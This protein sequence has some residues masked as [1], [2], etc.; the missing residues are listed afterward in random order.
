MKYVWIIIVMLILLAGAFWAGT[1][2]DPPVLLGGGSYVNYIGQATHT[3]TTTRDF[4]QMVKLLDANRSRIYAR[5]D[6]VSA[7]AVYLYFPTSTT[8]ITNAELRNL[9]LEGI[10][11]DPTGNGNDSYT[12]GS[13]NLYQGLVYATGTVSGLQINITES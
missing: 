13:D 7:T 1:K 11:L 8:H 5:F 9:G 10:R 3:S 4:A 12:I 2:Y 6:N